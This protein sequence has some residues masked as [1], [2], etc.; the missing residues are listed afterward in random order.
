MKQSLK[1]FFMKYR[2]LSPPSCGR[3]VTTFDPL[4]E[5]RS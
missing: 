1:I 5:K 2:L 3:S 4:W